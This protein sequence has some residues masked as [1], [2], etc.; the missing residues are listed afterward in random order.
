MGAT[1]CDFW[2]PSLHAWG[3]H[4]SFP[5]RIKALAPKGG[6]RLSENAV[7]L[8]GETNRILTEPLEPFSMDSPPPSHSTLPCWL[9]APQSGVAR[10]G[11]GELRGSWARASM[12][13]ENAAFAIHRVLCSSVHDDGVVQAASGE[14]GK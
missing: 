7:C 4:G 2:Y 6:G 11:M 5:N 14:D 13:F 3:T 10:T 12:N 9:W 8:T 1:P